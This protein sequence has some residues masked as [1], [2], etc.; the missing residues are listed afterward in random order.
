M[1]ANKRHQF[2]NSISLI[3]YGVENIIIKSEK[4]ARAVIHFKK[5]TFKSPNGEQSD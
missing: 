1:D 5:A 2:I 3:V 4:G